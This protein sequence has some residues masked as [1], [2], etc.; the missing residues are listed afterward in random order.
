MVRVDGRSQLGGDIMIHGN[1]VSIGCLA[2]GDSATEYLFVP[3]AKLGLQNIELI[4][5]SADFRL[6]EAAAYPGAPSWLSK[7]YSDIHKA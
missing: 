7:L 5:T 3:A 1:C 6:V 4:L 2:M